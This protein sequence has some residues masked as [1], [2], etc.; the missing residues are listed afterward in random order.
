[1]NIGILYPL[2]LL[3]VL[4]SLV[5]AERPI[6]EGAPSGQILAT[7]SRRVIVM[8]PAGEVIWQHKGENVSDCWMQ[9]NGRVLIADNRVFEIVSF[10]IQSDI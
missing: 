6:I 7:G 1:M 8:N 2:I 4:S 5:R 3:T 10:S 9:E